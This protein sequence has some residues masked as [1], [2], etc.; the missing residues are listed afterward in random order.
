[1]VSVHESEEIL[2]ICGYK[3]EVIDSVLSRVRQEQLQEGH[4]PAAY[5]EHLALDFQLR[6]HCDKIKR[7]GALFKTVDADDDG[8]INHD[9]LYVLLE[10]L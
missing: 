4:L 8:I 1:M 10:K 7:V 3:R 2:L 9:Q 6:K 5:L